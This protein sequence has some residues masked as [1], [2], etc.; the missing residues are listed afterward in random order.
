MLREKILYR[1]FIHTVSWLTD[2]SVKKKAI[3]N[4][5]RRMASSILELVRVSPIN[6]RELARERELDSRSH[7]H[8]GSRSDSKR[9]PNA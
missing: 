9:I 2:S 7:P 3:R 1:N 6:W 4:L 5:V 8:S